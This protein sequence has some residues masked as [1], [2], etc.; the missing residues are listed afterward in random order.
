M[1]EWMQTH[2]KWLVITI[3]IATIA[4]IGAGFV[5][6]GQFQLS[7]K[8]GIVAE[9]QD[10][11]V[12][13]QEWQ[14]AYNQVFNMYNQQFGGRLTQEMA[15]KLGLKQ[16]AL[17]Q[18]IQEAI[19]RQLAKNL[20]LYITDKE[21]ADKILEVFK[22]KKNYEMY[23]R[24][25][26]I[27]PAEF[28]KNLRR[29]MLV[30]KLL[31]LLHLKPTKTEILTVG[32]ALYNADDL[33]IKVLRKSDIP[34][35][36]TEK[37]I[38]QYWKKHK[39]EFLTQEKYKIAIIQIPLNIK[40]SDTVLKKYYEQHKLNY[41]NLQGVIMSFKQAKKLVKRDYAK[42][43]LFKKAVLAYKNLQSD[44][45]NYQLITVSAL[46]NI[47]PENEL[48]ILVKKG[49][50]KPFVYNNKYIIAKL[51]EKINP[52]P[53]SFNK[54]KPYVIEK[55]LSLKEKEKLVNISKKEYKTFKG[56]DIGFVTKYDAL[57]IKQLKP[58]QAVE[59]LQA[60]FTSQKPNY[61]VLLPKS[62]PNVSVL[63]KI[64]EQ[65]LLNKKEFEKNKQNVVQLTEGLI[66]MELLNNL[67]NTLAQTYKIKVFVK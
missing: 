30:E 41:K 21:L 55:L 52:K 66:N 4:F 2:R 1:I 43:K 65:K 51:I 36:L 58:A 18:A 39:N 47:I 6:W 60:V 46:N 35:D 27:K 15:K 28:E 64:K 37:E 54:A 32:S 49:I 57:K 3:W 38:K 10:T 50:V 13:M 67:I 14:E 44:K 40:V 16:I 17:Q 62:N 22:T 59:F 26:G 20:G 5:G 9:V 25:I 33:D 19:L 42:E 56:T 24:N 29:K 8:E 48:S 53:L 34:I 23:L 31:S 12:T 61:F 7:R 45:G 63:Y 11:P